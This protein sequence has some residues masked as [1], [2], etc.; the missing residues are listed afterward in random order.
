T[1]F[2]MAPLKVLLSLCYLYAVTSSSDS[3]ATTGLH[4]MHSCRENEFM[5][6]DEVA[7]IDDSWLCDG[8]VDCDDWS[9]EKGC[10]AGEQSETPEMIQNEEK[11]KTA[12]VLESLL[13]LDRNKRSV[14][15]PSTTRAPPA[16][17]VDMQFDPNEE[18]W[19]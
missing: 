16:D 8:E 15:L 10:G 12:N 7:C 11:E 9:D 4:S 6:H 18:L 14:E 2:R 3:D 17:I 1:C 5:C 13:G 19:E